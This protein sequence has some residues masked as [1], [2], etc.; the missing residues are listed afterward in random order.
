LLFTLYVGIT[1]LKFCCKYH[2]YCFIVILNLYLKRELYMKIDIVCTTYS[3]HPDTVPPYWIQQ[4]IVEE[5][6]KVKYFNKIIIMYNLS[7]L[8]ACL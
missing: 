1:H 2:N 4:L 8:L 3:R 5:Q 6:G 7:P